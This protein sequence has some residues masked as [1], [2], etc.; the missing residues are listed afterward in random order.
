MAPDLFQGEPDSSQGLP[1]SSI[2]PVVAEGPGLSHRV[3]AALEVTGRG[4]VLVDSSARGGTGRTVAW[5]DLASTPFEK[6][7]GPCRRTRSAQRGRG[8]SIGSSRWSRCQL[9]VEQAPGVKD[10]QLMRAFVTAARSV[11]F[12]D[13]VTV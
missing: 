4:W 6:Q 10:H 9:G 8:A 7:T 3:E 5:D 11:E 13:E 12:Q 1:R 2:L